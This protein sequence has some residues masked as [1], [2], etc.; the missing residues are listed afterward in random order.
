MTAVSRWLRHPVPR[1]L[2]RARPATAD[3][4]PEARDREFQRPGRP[5][6]KHQQII[7]C[8]SARQELGP[9][10]P[11]PRRSLRPVAAETLVSFDRSLQV[12][13]RPVYLE[14][15]MVQ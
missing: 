11:E 4:T 6:P 8:R 1:R 12:I 13:H 14:S 3:T 9:G 5:P 10:Q 2:A 7:G 15:A